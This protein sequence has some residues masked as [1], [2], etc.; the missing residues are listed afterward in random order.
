MTHPRPLLRLVPPPKSRPDAA[1]RANL[2]YIRETMER[3]GSFTAVPGVGGVLMGVSALIA[4]YASSLQKTPTAWLVVWLIEALV[5]SAVGGMSMAWKARAAGLSL[6]RGPGRRF[7]MN[8]YPPLMVGAL[9]T[10]ALTRA[11]MTSLLPSV[12]L[13][14]YGTA[15][16]TGG[17]FSVRIVPIMGAGFITVGAAALLMPA[18]WGTACLAVGFGGLHIGFGL[19]IARRHGG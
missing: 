18:G 5:A 1:A 12:W 6:R 10:L 15:V 7:A 3:A 8:H 14:L 13:L 2:R 19:A 4:A 16:M 9:L 11:G 17:A